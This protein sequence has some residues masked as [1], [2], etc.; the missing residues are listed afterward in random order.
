MKFVVEFIEN[1]LVLVEHKGLKFEL[2][3]DRFLQIIRENYTNNKTNRIKTYPAS[4][5]KMASK[6]IWDCSTGKII[7][8]Y[9]P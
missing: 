2:N 7:K 6:R 8:G 1:D 4:Q 3:G 5:L 9:L